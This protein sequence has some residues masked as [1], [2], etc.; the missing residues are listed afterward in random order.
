[1]RLS[2]LLSRMAKPQP[3]LDANSASEFNFE[4]KWQGLSSVLTDAAPPNDRVLCAADLRFR[5]GERELS[6]L[7]YRPGHAPRPTAVRPGPPAGPHTSTGCSPL[8]A[9]GRAF[10]LNRWRRVRPSAADRNGLHA[11]VRLLRSGRSWCGAEKSRAGYRWG[12]VSVNKLGAPHSAKHDRTPP[13]SN[14]LWDR[15][16]R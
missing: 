13:K 12:Q 14:L 4:H 1:M 7:G 10:R 2:L 3:E 11:A 16:V 9:A 6:A 5:C 15:T 8:W